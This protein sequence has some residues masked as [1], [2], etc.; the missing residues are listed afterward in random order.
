MVRVPHGTQDGFASIRLQSYS[1]PSFTYYKQ[2]CCD[3][4]ILQIEQKTLM[5]LF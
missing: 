2:R 5:S 3:L 4:I 1:N